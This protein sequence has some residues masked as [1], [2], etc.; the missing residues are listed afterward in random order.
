MKPIFVN[1]FPYLLFFP[2]LVL[3]YSS[4]LFGQALE[5]GRYQVRGEQLEE[6]QLMADGNWIWQPK[7]ELPPMQIWQLQSTEAKLYGL[8]AEGQFWVYVLGDS[9]MQRLGKLPDSLLQA[10]PRLW[11]STRVNDKHYYLYH[12]RLRR[13]WLWH[14]EQA[15]LEPAFDSVIYDISSQWVYHPEQEKL[16]SFDK[17]NRLISRPL[18]KRLPL[19]HGRKPAH[20]PR[21]ELEALRLWPQSGAQS[22]VLEQ[23][24][25]NERYYLDL[26]QEEV[27]PLRRNEPGNAW[28]ALRG[29]F[30]LG[31]TLPNIEEPLLQFRLIPGQQAGWWTVL[32]DI[33]SFWPARLRL[34]TSSDGRTWELLDERITEE[35]GQTS[36]AF[37][38]RLLDR[39]PWQRGQNPTRYYRLRLAHQLDGRQYLSKKIALLNVEEPTLAAASFE[40]DFLYLPVKKSYSNKKLFCHIQSLDAGSKKW[41]VLLQTKAAATLAYTALEALPPGLYTL[42]IEG[43]PRQLLYKAQ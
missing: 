21:K 2:I 16:Y 41:R 11:T 24:K 1:M 25:S 18:D 40:G 42:Y 27:V 32:A 26:E 12:R 35:P 30:A 14:L 37:P 36:A 5:A 33:R 4:N 19:R 9:S 38:L 8:D 28:Q 7:R 34:E 43:Y 29:F 3:L 13:F 31:Q 23:G 20:L 17:F 10:D 39:R 6:A 22:F 15:H